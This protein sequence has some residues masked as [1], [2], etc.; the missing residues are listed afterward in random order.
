[1][2]RYAL[3]CSGGHAFD[4]WFQSAGAFDSLKAAGHL[5]CP[6]CGATE[7]EKSLMAPQVRPA[8]PEA[9]EGRELSQPQDAREAR[10]AALRRHVEENSEYVGM[11][12]AAEARKMH[13]GAAPHRSIYGETRPE[14]ARALIEDGVPV[15]PLPFLPNRRAN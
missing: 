13:E 15:A 7:V 10:L 2:I 5:A 4:S 12:F 14:E 3:K 8:R 11:K 6:D 9:P 1:M